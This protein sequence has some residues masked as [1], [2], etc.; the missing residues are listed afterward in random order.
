MRITCPTCSTQYD[1]DENDIAFTGQDVQCS[2]CMT[3][4]TQARNGETSNTR[5]ADEVVENSD[6]ISTAPEETS[7][8]ET[9][10]I[11]GVSSYFDVD[12]ENE[13][14]ELEEVEEVEI[15]PFRDTN[16]FIERGKPDGND[17]PDDTEEPVELADTEADTETDDAEDGDNDE[18]AIWKRIEALAQEARE[19]TE[20]EI[21]TESD[22]P[23]PDDMPPIQ[24]S[25]VI[26]DTIEPTL[27][28][29]EEDDRPWE[30]P[31]EA[32]E[33]FSD[34]VWSDPLKDNDE[35]GADNHT[36]SAPDDVIEQDEPEVPTLVEDATDTHLEQVSDDLIAA[37]LSEQMAIEDA[38]ESA[39]QPEERDIS[40]IPVEL[41][42]PRARVPNVEA[43][44]TSV[45]S[46]SVTLTKEERA[47]KA[48]TRRFRR[49]FTLIL[50]AFVILA[51]IYVANGKITEAL[52]AI[53]PF[54][55]TYVSLVDFLRIK[56]ELLGSSVWTLS[57]Q[58]FDWVMAKFFS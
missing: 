58:G 35:E 41:G 52:P 56:A 10:D 24:S 33:G 38:L 45:R 29:P 42:G 44:K 14:A 51:A 25:P 11:E 23:P 49:G 48:P 1:V 34:F 21:P 9:P 19:D 39:P 32:D 20:G 6:E 2:E 4:W 40:S 26:P 22:S 3:I 46:K 54:M 53:G 18:G 28:A 27:E 30:A 16:E 15:I 13:P 50:L 57:M 17:M 36:D 7:V 43:L 37:A 47:A 31:A 5:L 12:T 8:T 55:E